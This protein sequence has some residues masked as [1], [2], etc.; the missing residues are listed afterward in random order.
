MQEQLVLSSL[1]ISAPTFVLSQPALNELDR[2]WELFKA[3]EHISIQPPNA[4]VSFFPTI[5]FVSSDYEQIILEDMHRKAHIAMD[6]HR[7]LSDPTIEKLRGVHPRHPPRPRTEERNRAQAHEGPFTEGLQH[8]GDQS[9]NMWPDS[10][11]AFDRE[12]WR[13]YATP[14]ATP[15]GNSLGLDDSI[16]ADITPVEP[17]TEQSNWESFIH[18]LGEN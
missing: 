8:S 3:N 6:E 5:L 13:L 1:V 7:A 14:A 18:Q 4:R 17:G 12:D 10:Q 9:W 16:Y 15:P 2:A 11:P